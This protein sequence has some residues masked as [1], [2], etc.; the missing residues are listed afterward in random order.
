MKD[1]FFIQIDRNYQENLDFI[2]YFSWDDWFEIFN[3]WLMNFN[4]YD[5]KE[6]KYYRLFF[7]QLLKLCKEEVLK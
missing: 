4:F 1:L 7:N 3:E 2:K 5:E 6:L